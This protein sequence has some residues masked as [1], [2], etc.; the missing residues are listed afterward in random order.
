[1]ATTLQLNKKTKE[2][3]LIVKARLE[4]ETGKK[5][6]LDD[7][8]RWLI[9]KDRSPNV[10]ERLKSTNESFGVIKDLEITLDDLTSLRKERSSRFEDI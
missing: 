7:A 3:L 1:M 9:E 8:I 5:H 10:D 6:T 2:E 4:Q